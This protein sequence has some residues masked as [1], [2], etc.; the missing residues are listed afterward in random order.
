M[1]FYLDGSLSGQWSRAV[2][3]TQAIYPLTNGMHHF[4]WE[5]VKDKSDLG[6][7]DTAWIDDVPF[8]GFVDS[9]DDGMPDGWEID[10]DL[11]AL[12]NDAGNDADGDLFTNGMECLMGTDPN[13]PADYPTL[14]KGFDADMD[15][16]G[17]DL[18]RM[19]EGLASGIVAPAEVQT[20]AEG[21]GR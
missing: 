11:D 9:D 10:H 19:A 14:S 4:R 2:P 21:F 12:K 13:N 3:Y 20:F 15:V 5:Y 8:P 18:S 6:G 7:S 17:A 1:Y 16:D